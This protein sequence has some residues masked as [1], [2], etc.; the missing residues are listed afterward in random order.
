MIQAY[1]GGHGRPMPEV[2]TDSP[3]GSRVS[4]WSPLPADARGVTVRSTNRRRRQ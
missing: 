2:R 3:R 1:D 4:C